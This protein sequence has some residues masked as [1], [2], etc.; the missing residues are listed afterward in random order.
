MSNFYIY[1]IS[2]LPMLHFGG[3]LPFSY[4]KFL[5]MCE[6][7]IPEGELAVIASIVSEANEAKQSPRFKEIAS[8]AP[9]QAR[10]PLAMTTLNKWQAF[11]TALRNELV[12][13]RSSRKHI[14]YVRYLRREEYAQPYITHAAMNAYRNTSILDAERILD[15]ERWR[16]L[17][18][19]SAGHYF[20]RDFLVVY[21]LKLRILERWEKINSANNA[22][23]VERLCYKNE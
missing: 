1:L 7:L 6:G 2:S 5:A 12:K 9:R 4:E 13:I 21:A 16:A 15:Q 18:E 3:R 8:V 23:E 11:D 19:F 22:Q 20:D 17:D 14:D 10:D